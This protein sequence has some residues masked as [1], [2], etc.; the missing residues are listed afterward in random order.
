M[1]RSCIAQGAQPG[2]LWQPKGAGW[3]GGGGGREK[4]QEKGDICVL[5]ADSCCCMEKAKT[6]L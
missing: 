5:V 4:A 6:I 3:N 1:G 2:A